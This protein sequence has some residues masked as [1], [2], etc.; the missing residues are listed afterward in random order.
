[1]LSLGGFGPWG[2]VLEGMWSLVFGGW[3]LEGYVEADI[4][5]SPQT[6]SGSHCSGRYAS[7]WNVFFF[8]EI[9]PN[10]IV[11]NGYLESALQ[12]MQFIKQRSMK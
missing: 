12:I 11:A 2:V 1:M 5:P 7:Y 3:S 6:S 4:D 8:L 10:T 9:L